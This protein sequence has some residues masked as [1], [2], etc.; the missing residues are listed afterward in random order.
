MDK[1]YQVF[2]SSTYADLKEE[3]RAV[4]Q[5]VVEQNCIPA[6]M[7]LFPATD[8]QQLAFIKRII[9]DCDYYLVIV[10]GRYGSVAADGVSYTEKE[11]DYAVSRGLH[12]IALV[13]EDPEEIALS[14]SEKDPIL[15]ERLQQFRKRVCTDRVVKTWK[16]IDQLPGFVAQ[17]LSH[18]MHQFPAVGWVRANKVANEEILSE[19]N[20][21]RKQNSRL[22]SVLRELKPIPAV[23]DLAG[24][25]EEVTIPGK[26]Y[27]SSYRMY[28]SWQSKTTWRNIFKHISPYLVELP[29]N[30][31]VKSILCEALG[32]EKD[33]PNDNRSLDDQSFR[34]VGIQLEALGLVKIE[35]TLTVAGGMDLFWSATPAG[36]R[37]MLQTRTVRTAS[38]KE[39]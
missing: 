35:Y 38:P 22:M 4:I 37:L 39:T 26:Y 6:G 23:E 25:D 2:V 15:R 33:I 7:E 8:E 18:A 10:A 24:L 13:H 9:D 17:S 31:R 12:V 1:R 34:T 28:Q 14:K 11:Y 19:V 30:T 36:K 3:R 27:Y 21:L 16:S 32:A 29:N 20:E 5:A